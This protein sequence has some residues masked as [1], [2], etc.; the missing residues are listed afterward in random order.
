MDAWPLGLSNTV[1][2]A[3]DV[4]QNKIIGI[5]DLQILMKYLNL[6]N[7]SLLYMEEIGTIYFIIYNL[8]GGIGLKLERV[9]SKFSY[10]LSKTLKDGYD[11]LGWTGSNGDTPE[12][13]VII[14]AGTTENLEFT[15]HWKKIP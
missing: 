14:E 11:F 12:P 9:A 3:A 8:D 1:L 7:I 10:E 2:C 6:Y 5:I 15:A 4:F 13:E